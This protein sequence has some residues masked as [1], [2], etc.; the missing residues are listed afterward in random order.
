MRTESICYYSDFQEDSKMCDSFN[1]TFNSSVFMNSIKTSTLNVSKLKEVLKPSLRIKLSLD[2]ITGHK[3]SG[4]LVVALFHSD[5][6]KSA[7][8]YHVYKGFYAAL[9]YYTDWKQ[10]MKNKLVKQK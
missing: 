2:A 6:S 8:L 9:F 4:K 1:F 3:E 5:Q 7:S 10:T